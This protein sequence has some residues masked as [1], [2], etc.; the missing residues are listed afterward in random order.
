[1]S[2]NDN[3]IAE[4]ERRIERLEHAQTGLAAIFQ[5]IAELLKGIGTK[6]AE[7]PELLKK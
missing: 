4:L 7:I 5:R 1:M 6:A 2:A 3:K